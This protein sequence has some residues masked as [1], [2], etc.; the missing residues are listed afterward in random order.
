MR[1]II[2]LMTQYREVCHMLSLNIKV[3]SCS[4]FS[5]SI[6]SLLC[7][8]NLTSRCFFF[9]RPDVSPCYV[10]SSWHAAMKWKQLL[11]LTLLH[12]C[13]RRYVLCILIPHI[14][15]IFLS[16]P[17][18]PLHFFLFL[19][20]E[21]G[22]LKFPCCSAWVVNE[23]LDSITNMQCYWFSV[24]VC[25]HVCVRF[26]VHVF[27]HSWNAKSGSTFQLYL[28][29]AERVRESE[30]ETAR[31]LERDCSSDVL[32]NSKSLRPGR[33]RYHENCRYF[34]CDGLL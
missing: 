18:P 16:P 22:I 24:S 10:K 1:R 17:S 13:I 8:R 15:A 32:E 26:C 5:S 3:H 12:I 34:H 9:F 33:F 23:V 11:V 28:H 30:T 7:F 25:V 31:Q 21:G 4:I 19:P 6:D 27:N 20:K 29:H 2:F 14:H